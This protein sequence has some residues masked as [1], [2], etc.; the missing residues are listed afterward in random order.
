MEPTPA[1]HLPAKV[2]ARSFSGARLRLLAPVLEHRLSDLTDRLTSR[3][4]QEIPHYAS[5]AAEE[6][7]DQS[8][9]MLRYVLDELGGK[10]VP[11]ENGPAAY[12][13]I[14]AEQGVPPEVVLR[15]FR[16]AWAELWSG[17][18]AAAGG[19]GGLST[20]ELLRVSTD[21]F[22]MADDYAERMLVAYRKRAVELLVRQEAERSATLEGVFSG[23]LHGAEALWEAAALLD[24]PYEGLFIVVA[25]TTPVAGREALPGIQQSLSL[26]KLNSSWRLG[27]DIE[28]G[29]VSLRTRT[30]L[31]PLLHELSAHGT[32]RVA[33]SAPYTRLADTPHALHLARLVLGTIPD[34][35]ADIK[36][37]DESPMG[38]LLAAS[39]DTARELSK[40]V[41]GGLIE[42]PE[43]DT[44]TLLLT[45]S[46]WFE[47]AGSITE[48]AKRL[49]L[50]PNTVRYRLRR[51]QS[52]TQRSLEDPRDVA[53][54][55]TALIAHDMI[56]SQGGN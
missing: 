20:D 51:I 56:P 33:L 14:R 48:A 10:P 9:M 27:P 37:F 41:L 54:I 21:V 5:M 38:A 25:A 49:Y 23:Y 29:I 24:L 7:R 8:E 17:L 52:E 26:A 1:G 35:A 16:V 39:P 31:G 28:A 4:R 47:S 19:E 40:S 45:L 55:R 18:L 11:S 3:L 36:Q 43:E 46:T 32:A 30:M 6:L 13:R 15:A 44:K 50:H 34:G 12:G 42:L 22:W 53:E 2:T